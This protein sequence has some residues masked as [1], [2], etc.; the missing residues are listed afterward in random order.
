M[1]L[2]QLLL[3]FV[4][5][6]YSSPSPWSPEIGVRGIEEGKIFFT[7]PTGAAEPAPVKTSIANATF[8]GMMRTSDDSVPYLVLTGLPC[9]GCERQAAVYLIRGDGGVVERFVHP[10][11]VTDARK[12]RLVYESSAYFGQC[13]RDKKPVYVAFQR[14]KADRRRFMQLSVLR[15]DIG[16]ERLEEK[17]LVR[18]LPSESLAKAAVRK[19]ICTRLPELKRKSADELLDE[20]GKVKR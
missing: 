10:G 4:T 8:H 6:A 15:V 2:L 9:A 1:E 3:F 19:K 20:D 12:G 7:A 11:Q 13:L 17:L 5:P 16:T 18:R 14:E